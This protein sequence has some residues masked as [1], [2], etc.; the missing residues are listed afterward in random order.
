MN[1]TFVD[2]LS[3]LDNYFFNIYNITHY[4]MKYSIN[5]FLTSCTLWLSFIFD[6]Q[7]NILPVTVFDKIVM[8][9]SQP[10]RP[11][12]CSQKRRRWTK[13]RPPHLRHSSLCPPPRTPSASR[14]LGGRQTG[15]RLQAGTEKWE[16]IDLLLCSRSW[17]T[18]PNS[19]H[20]YTYPCHLSLRV[21]QPV[22]KK[23]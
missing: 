1:N 14:S 18:K 21:D 7:L 2:K 12:C 16:N 17:V 6:F 4:I 3:L 13:V 10:F 5:T 15:K 20:T 19:C 11:P 22:V 23:Y 8:S 9:L